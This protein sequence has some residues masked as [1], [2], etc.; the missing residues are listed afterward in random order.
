MWVLADLNGPTGF[1]IKPPMTTGQSLGSET[2]KIE[3]S[4]LIG[5]DLMVGEK[6]LDEL[7]GIAEIT[8][9]KNGA[10]S[11]ASVKGDFVGEGLDFG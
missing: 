10:A 8:I 7:E 9:A 2:S 3:V 6:W 1:R 11:R 5:R 4:D